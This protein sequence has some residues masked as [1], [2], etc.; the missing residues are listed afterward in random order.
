MHQL[1]E[2]P[3]FLTL[4]IGKTMS[5]L[6]AEPNTSI[7]TDGNP[8]PIP[9]VSESP[10]PAPT[11][12]LYRIVWRWHFYA[13]VLVA[14]FL[15]VVAITGAIYVFKDELDRVIHADTMFVA[16]Q[17]DRVP[18]EQ[19]VKAAEE[20]FP[21]CKADTVEVDT[22][23]TRATS[24]RIRGGG[25][26][27][28]RVYVNPHTGQ[29]QGAIGD[30][31]FFRV[32]LD[33]HRRLFL[34]TTGRVIVETDTCWTVVLLLTGLYL[35]F[36]R[37]STLAG[38]LVPRLRAKPYT[39]LRDLHAITGV[40]TLPVALTVVLTGLVYSFI[41]GAGYSSVSSGGVGAAASLKS[42]SPPDAP[43]LPLD[44]AVA[45]T[46]AHYPKATFVDVLLPAKKDGVI[47]G[48]AKWSETNGPRSQI[49][50]A[51]DRSTGD[52]LDTQSSDNFPPLRWWRTTWNYP[53]HTGSVLGTPTK[54][55]WLIVCL[56]LATLPVTG[57]WMWWKRRPAGRTGFPRRPDRRLPSWLIGA[58]CVMGVLLPTV[59]ASV[60]L[61][62]VG[63]WVFSR[64]R[65]IWNG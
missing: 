29:V 22:D 16:P 13:G 52:V 50:L 51:L 2:I 61:M 25:G 15:M 10:T 37:R 58:L 20:A 14:P 3:A 45:V 39:V 26:G 62:V 9:A 40:V 55:L 54:V 64:L 6:P 27:T 11:T 56:V 19:Q 47:V 49:V 18:L 21:G 8:A 65:S 35:W 17:P 43:P 5:Q 7:Q 32:V 28:R 34:G 53:L 23:P 4:S 31:S 36:P 12:S 48:R 63:E 1:T 38:V 59:G 46:R 33:L 41:W 60:V 30:D 44:R 42:T 24:I 57:V